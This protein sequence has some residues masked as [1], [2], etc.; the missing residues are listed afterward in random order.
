MLHCQTVCSNQTLSYDT[1]ETILNPDYPVPPKNTV[2]PYCQCRKLGTGKAPVWTLVLAPDLF[3]DKPVSY[4]NLY[5]SRSEIFDVRWH[6]TITCPPFDVVDHSIA[7]VAI[8]SMLKEGWPVGIL[9]FDLLWLTVCIPV[10]QAHQS[11]WWVSAGTG[12]E[13]G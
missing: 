11:V 5:T 9:N 10:Q 3:D 2:H 13:G 8:H 1:A 12:A 7:T 4:V 6:C